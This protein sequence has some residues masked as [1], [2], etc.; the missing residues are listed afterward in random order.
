MNNQ[1]INLSNAAIFNSQTVARQWF[2]FFI[3]K[4]NECLTVIVIPYMAN[5]FSNQHY[6]FSPIGSDLRNLCKNV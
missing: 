2:Q 4:M 3:Q 5:G 1:W 6:G